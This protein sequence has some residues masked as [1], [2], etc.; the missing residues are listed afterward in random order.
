MLRKDYLVKKPVEWIYANSITCRVE[1]PAELVDMTQ[2]K[3]KDDPKTF[4][5]EEA[6]RY[7]NLFKMQN[8]ITVKFTLKIILTQ[9]VEFVDYF[10]LFSKNESVA[11]L[12]FVMCTY[13][14]STQ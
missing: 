3:R 7:V 6:N 13:I 12:V 1:C 11:Y 10:L 9:F 8:Q 4:D 2:V 14:L 5:I